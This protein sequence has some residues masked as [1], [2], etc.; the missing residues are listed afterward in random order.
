MEYN[1]DAIL[2]RVKRAKTLSGLTNAELAERSGVPIG[3]INKIMAGNTQEPKLPAFISIAHA[4]DV[5][6]D[7]LVYGYTAKELSEDELVHIKKYRLLDQRGQEAVDNVLEHEY[8]AA[9]EK[10]TVFSKKQA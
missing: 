4:L 2:M 3:T 7:F 1:F 9:V 6:V 5:S 10:D 8:R